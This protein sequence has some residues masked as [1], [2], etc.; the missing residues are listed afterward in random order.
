MTKRVPFE[1]L[2]LH[3]GAKAAEFDDPEVTPVCSR[4]QEPLEIIRASFGEQD[5]A[6]RYP[7]IL[8]RCRTDDKHFYVTFNRKSERMRRT[9]A[10]EVPLDDD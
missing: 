2:D 10:G 6:G 4:C 3:D 5:A 9:L 7:P 1:D 8:V